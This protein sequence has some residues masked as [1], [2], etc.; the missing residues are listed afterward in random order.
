MAKTS[1][2]GSNVETQDSFSGWLEQTNKL[3]YDMGSVVLTAAAVNEPNTT[4]GAWT[5]GNTNLEGSFSA[6]VVAV[7]DTLRGGTV[8]QSGLLTISSNTTFTGANVIINSNT[9]INGTNTNITSNGTIFTSN[10]VI[11][12]LGSTGNTTVNTGVFFVHSNTSIDGDV[13]NVH[14]D[15]LDITGNT[16]VTATNFYV[17]TDSIE[18]ASN[19]DAVMV[20][21]AD[22]DFNSNVNIDGIT[23]VTANLTHSGGTA[24]FNND[25]VLGSSGTDTVIVNADVA[26]DVIPNANNTYD[27]GNDANYWDRLYVQDALVSANAEIEGK[28]VIKGNASRELVAQS[29]S[30]AYQDLKVTL[31]TSSGNEKNPI[32]ANS[33]VVAGGSANSTYDLGTDGHVWKKAFLKDL[34]VANSIVVDTRVDIGENLNVTGDTN[35]TGTFDVTGN[36]EFNDLVTIKGSSNFEIKAGSTVK[37]GVKGDTGNTD[38]QGTLDVAGQANVSSVMVRDLTA[39][40][41]TFAGTG[42]ELSDKNT[43]VFTSANNTLK[44]TGNTVITSDLS[45]GDD[46]TISDALTVGG[47]VN[48]NSTTA[49]ANATSAAVVI[50]GGVAIAQDTYFGDDDTGLFIDVSEGIYFEGKKHGITY[51]DGGGNF[52][53]RVGHN[54]TTGDLVTETGY[55]FHETFN[56]STGKIEHLVSSISKDLGDTDPTWFTQYS[57]NSSGVYLGYQGV[58]KFETQSTGAKVT[59]VL[60]VSSNTDIG[61]TLNVNDIVAEQNLRLATESTTLQIDADTTFTANSDVIFN[62]DARFAGSLTVDGDISLSVNT[63]IINY[64]TV[65]EELRF[66]V[67]AVVAD[68]FIPAN[69]SIRVGTIDDPFGSVTTE[70]L[71]LGVANSA[72][73]SPGKIQY[74]RDGNNDAYI[75][76]NETTDAWQIN[77]GSST[78]DIVGKIITSTS[79]GIAINGSAG[80]QS[81]NT[82]ITIDHEVPPAGVVANT[83]INVSEAATFNGVVITGLDLDFDKFGHTVGAAISTEDL[84][85]R[86]YTETESDTRFLNVSGDSMSGTLN[87]VQ[88]NITNIKDAGLANSV[89]HDGD[90]NTYMQFNAAD[91]W[92]VVTGGTE[93]LRA[94]TTLVTVN[95]N[96]AVTGNSIEISGAS[97]QVYFKDT[98]ASAD[99]FYAH[100][101]SN[102]FYILTDRGDDGTHETPNPLM[103]QNSDSTGHLYGNRLLT[104]ADEGS[105]NGLDADTVDGVH[106]SSLLRSDATDIKTAGGLRFNDNIALNFGTGTDVE[107]FNNGSD[108]YM[109][110]N[111]DHDLILRDGNSSNNVRFRF[112]TSSGNFTNDGTIVAGGA[113]TSNTDQNVFADDYHPNADKLTNARTISLGGDASGSISFDGSAN[114]TL[115]VTVANDSHTHDGRYYT[116]T[117]ADTRFLRGNT[118]DTMT[119]KLTITH[120]GNEML[121]LN[122]TAEDGSPHVSFDQNG[123]RRGYVQ[124]VGGTTNRMRIH[125]DVSSE[126][127]DIASGVDGLIYYVSGNEYTVWHAGNDGT[128]TGL[129]ADKVDGYHA[130]SFILSG[131]NQSVTANTEWADNKQVQLGTGSDFRMYHNGSHNYFDTHNG[132]LFVRDGTETTRYVQFDKSAGDWIVSHNIKAQGDVYIGKNG[133]G[134]SN[135]HFY[136]DNSNTWRTIFW[137]DSANHFKAELNDGTFQRILTA[138]DDGGIDADTVDGISS[139]SFIRSDADDNVSAHTEWQDSKEV[140]FGNGA[141]VKLMWNG[142]NFYHTQASGS[143]FVRTPSFFYLQDSDASNATRFTFSMNNGDLTAT[144]YVSAQGDLY[145]GKNGG[146]DSL[147]HFYDDN[148]NTHRTMRW[149][150]SANDWRVE[151]NGGTNRVLYHSGNL[152]VGNAT[153]T[154]QGTGAL[155][156]SGTITMNATTNKTISITHDDTSTQSS[157]NNSNGTVIQDVTLDGYGHTTGLSSVNLDNRYAK[158]ENGNDGTWNKMRSQE[159]RGFQ[160]SSLSGFVSSITEPYTYKIFTSKESYSSDAYVVAT[161]LADYYHC[162]QYGSL[163][164]SEMAMWVKNKIVTYVHGSANNNSLGNG[165]Y[166]SWNIQISRTHS[167]QCFPR[168]LKIEIWSIGTGMGSQ[169]ATYQGNYVMSTNG[170]T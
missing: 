70:R 89:Y 54:Y 104:T 91:S 108:L 154:V 51:N 102:N 39:G 144:G 149:D 163:D 138:A 17:R 161:R 110:L 143:T 164:A 157:V 84:D 72:V 141:D 28:L 116:E 83:V 46:V 106:V 50:D 7:Y 122:D 156:G 10:S 16:T 45:V 9:S 34:D 55:L 31:R 113:I 8:S 118:A 88:N 26:S 86:Y 145:V 6:N 97:P 69:T 96:L 136:D 71:E 73:Q 135:L 29:T 123:T 114:K 112:Y 40:Q 1:Y 130:S 67:G 43:F 153:L 100:V 12:N 62:A 95:D 30:T 168:N 121:V 4:N 48:L 41:V 37:F 90:T 133:G 107:I 61:G 64:L 53:I 11:F 44:V 47:L 132:D 158:L 105:G 170:L 160:V 68:N 131:S 14:V 93:R 139:G 58:Q 21:N 142:S 109:D 169:S 36:S 159:T 152:T 52:N 137:D 101:N 5:T 147:I 35:L 140:R 148:N 81:S 166:L 20:V 126:R 128:G 60:N 125:N 82:E 155:G 129:D 119:G 76:W 15:T 127:L 103:L 66:G 75:Q 167:E 80:S 79:G 2:L 117:E 42:G 25:V 22:T 49:A 56:Q 92:R 99:D 59:G 38:I 63:S 27:L 78:Y 124:F 151:D 165:T 134:D 150:D 77:N 13:A 19:G 33:S 146:G 162:R 57:A 18:L 65:N 74:T 85:G 3:I 23:T 94:N 32:I 120:A 98:T 24:T 111:G 87:M 115:T